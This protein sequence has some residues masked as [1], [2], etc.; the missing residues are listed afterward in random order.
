MKYFRAWRS[1]TLFFI[2]VGW[3]LTLGLSAQSNRTRPPAGHLIVKCRLLIDPGPDRVISDAFIEIVNGR[4]LRVGPVSE[5]P[6]SR[7]AK[8]LDF[9][10]KTIIP[11]LIDT[12][13]HLFGNI[14][15]SNDTF[16]GLL[17]KLPLACGV[18][19]VRA[20]GSFNPG[21]D[22]ALRDKIN[23]GIFDGPRI[24]LSGAILN[25]EPSRL[26]YM[27][28]VRTDEE[29]RLLIDHWAE[30]G[31]T[32][33]KLY[34]SFQG[35]LLK[36]AIDH[37]HLHGLRALAHLGATSFEDAIRA[38]IDEVFHGALAFKDIL[39]KDLREDQ[40]KE[41][42]QAFANMD[43]EGPEAER[44]LKLAADLR[45]VITPTVA[46]SDKM[47]FQGE[48][49]LSQKPYYTA[50]AWETAIKRE[51]NRIAP[52]EG[53]ASAGDKLTETFLHFLKKAYEAG[54]IL[55]TGTDK[56]S[57][58]PLPGFSLWHE[59]MAFAR[60]GLPAKAILKAATFNG[61]YALAVDN[62]LGSLEPGK[63][64]DF[65]VLDKNPMEDIKNIK[66][67]FR[68]I[69]GGIVYEP[70]PLLKRLIGIIE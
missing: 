66:T 44:L 8:I 56:T 37:A 30:R 67:V 24:Y 3:L 6:E 4:I 7:N 63:F 52:G 60:A 9:G 26:R 13:F 14:V 28:L 45:V 23:A 70:E 69:K 27:N 34:E 20:P 17:I 41:Y 51:A 29:V 15:R 55:T 53:R 40:S 43:L 65:V 46:M 31:A 57:M 62:I 42:V 10:D 59:M 39:P 21:G 48:F 19:T 58:V 36:T 35:D 18:T 1:I 54:C 22:F 61:A 25:M 64:A 47:D 16:T 38:G 5:M 2:G 32:S 33:I 11:G 49:L 50:A 12:H 68:V